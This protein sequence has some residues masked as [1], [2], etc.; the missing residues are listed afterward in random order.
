MVFSS[1]IFLTLFLPLVFLVYAVIQEKFRCA[2]LFIASI[3]F[4]AWGEPKAIFIM[5]L[6]IVF[7]FYV[8]IKI[9][10]SEHLVR[11]KIYVVAAI[12]LNLFFLFVYKYLDFVL[13]NINSIFGTSVSLPGIALPIGISFY[14]FQCLSYVVDVYRG[15]T[16]S[17]KSFILLGL[18]ISFFPQLIAGPIIRY[19]DICKDLINRKIIFQNCFLGF[20]RFAV[21]LAKKVLIADP[22]GFMVDKIFSVPASEI[23]SIWAWIGIVC[24]GLQIFYDFSAYS[25]M[26]I[27]LGKV[28]NF[29]F[30]ENFKYPYSSDSI[31]EFWRRWH[32]SLSTWLRDYLYIPLG[33]NRISYFRTLLNIWIVFILCGLWHGAAWTFVI[34]GFWHGLGLTIE[35]L[36][37]FSVLERIPYVFRNIWVWLWISIGW[38]FF[39]SPDLAYSVDYIEAMFLGNG[40]SFWQL[41]QAYEALTFSWLFSMLAGILFSYPRINRYFSLRK[42]SSLVILL[43]LFLFAIAYI[44]AVTSSFS[45]FI[46][47]RF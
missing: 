13:L 24:Y 5:L 22:M 20:Q 30:L 31:K 7:N 42:E 10:E 29:N 3:F 46:Y 4:Y 44:F 45:P 18:Y 1:A 16:H 25:D 47:F 38:V 8:A 21:G 39:R 33:G 27:G 14:C 43:S 17:Q 26:A 23:S 34:W 41:M 37:F 36:G 9:E 40:A 35:R 2:W 32:I 15:S 12:L 6:M 19:T 28:F 11:K